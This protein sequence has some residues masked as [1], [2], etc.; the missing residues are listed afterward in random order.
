L[1]ACSSDDRPGL[2]KPDAGDPGSHDA[3]FDIVINPDGPSTRFCDLPGSVQFTPN[4]MAMVN[5]GVGVDRVA[6]LTLPTGFCVHYFGNVGNTRQLRF[7]PTGDLFVAS[8]TT[9]TTGGGAGGKSAIVILPDDDRDGVA[10]TTVTF[11]GD[12]PSTQGIMFANDFFYYQNGTRIFR[13]PY[14]AGSRRP[15]DVFEQILDVNVYASTGHWP[16]PL[17]Q[18]DDGTIYV[19]NGGDQGETCVTPHPFHGGILKIDGTPGGRVVA[20]GFRNPIAVRCQRGHNLCFAVE[21]A[22]DF[23]AEYGGRE[24]LVPIRDG[25]DWGYPCCFTKD[26]AAPNIVP[27]PDCSGTTPETV[28]FLIGDTPFGVD[29]EPGKW[30]A[31]YSGAAFVTV[32]GA[33]STWTGARL[34]V[35]DVDPATGLPRPGSNLP[36]VSNGAM[37]VFGTG[38]D[39]GTRAHGR[40]SAIAF[41]PDGR[42]FI[43]NDNNGDIFWVAPLD[44]AR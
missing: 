43:G 40:P 39:D 23:S 6:F 10:D 7:S 26:R 34:V 12:L 15:A 17:D 38:W 41:A 18:A 21:L 20:K 8:P 35:I 14:A 1:A 29:F 33:Y 3:S 22:M 16:K 27:A 19:G 25:D 11:L 36:D 24:K 32:H 13:R 4:G 37:G 44:L 5:G 2:G 42:L 9:G 28:S 31:P 30:A